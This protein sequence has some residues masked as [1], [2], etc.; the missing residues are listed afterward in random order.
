MKVFTIILLI[1]FIP[2][3][4]TFS[5]SD[6]PLVSGGDLLFYIDKTSFQGKENKTY[7]EF[8]IM[9]YADY[10]KLQEASGKYSA[11]IKI[12]YELTDLNDERV[13]SKSWETVALFDSVNDVKSLVVYD[14]WGE[15][16]PGGK[17]KLSVGI[18]DLASRKMGKINSTIEIKDFAPEVFDL[19]EIQFLNGT[20]E[21]ESENEKILNPA[22]RYGLLNPI[23]YFYYELYNITVNDSIAIQYSVTDE[24]GNVA[25]ELNSVVE[26]NENSKGFIQGINVSKLNSGVYTFTIKA[27]TSSGKEISVKRNFEILQ[28]DY[29]AKT[30]ILSKEDSEMMEKLLDYIAEPYQLSQYKKLNSFNKANFILNFFKNLDPNPDTEENEYLQSLLARFHYANQKFSWGNIEGYTTEMGRIFIQN[31]KPDEVDYH[32]MDM[33]SR[34]YQI[35]Y[36]RG[37]REL[38]YVFGDLNSNGRYSL[39][40][41]NKEGE[42]YNTSWREL[43]SRL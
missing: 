17:Y 31:G 39:L 4:Q 20:K 41:S 26:V 14:N 9:I 13:N 2:I 16:T 37:N 22:R 11:S 19:S 40:H 34:P 30:P 35:W 10:L 25:K 8:S 32:N 12:D 18:K 29:F 38:F 15:L 1:I 27:K 28:L 21:S 42:I 6:K 43:V 24:A 23:L 33:D 3:A 36:Y 7:S 5:Q